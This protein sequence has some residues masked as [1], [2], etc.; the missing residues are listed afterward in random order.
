MNAAGALRT[1]VRAVLDLLYPRNCAAC[2]APV[3][4]GVPFSYL[5]AACAAHCAPYRGAYCQTC[6]MPMPGVPLSPKRC[7]HCAER[8]PSFEIGRTCGAMRGSL[9]ALIHALKYHGATSVVDDMAD[10]AAR[11]DGYLAFLQGA[12]LVPVPLHPR[13][14]RERGF[15]QS[16][17]IAAALCRRAEGAV[18][19]E[20]LRRTRRTPSQTRLSAEERARNVQGAFSRNPRA[21]PIEKE[22]LHIATI[23]HG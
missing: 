7:A 20:L 5:C 6:G 1:R 3:E 12:V 11:T 13:K 17:R 2:G 18:V 16:E 23:A 15:N 9:R 4:D 22:R 10:L 14:Q 8:D 21:A 19:R